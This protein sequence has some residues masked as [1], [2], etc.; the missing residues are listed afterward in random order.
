MEH[1]RPSRDSLKCVTAVGSLQG[2]F[3]EYSLL[4]E[5]LLF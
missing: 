4:Y 2:L 5:V 1:A 3:A